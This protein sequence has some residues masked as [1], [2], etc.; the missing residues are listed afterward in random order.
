[1]LS[2]VRLAQEFWVE[3]V[4]NAKYLVNMSPLSALFDS[5]RLQMRYGLVRILR[6]HISKYLDVMHLFMFLRTRG[7]RWTRWKSSV[8]SLDTKKE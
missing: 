8:F 2:D 5:T 7:E 3:A 4:D 6:F 1:M